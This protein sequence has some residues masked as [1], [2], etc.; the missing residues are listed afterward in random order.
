MNNAQI[1]KIYVVFYFFYSTLSVKDFYSA[2][3]NGEKDVW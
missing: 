2:G 1:S 3:D